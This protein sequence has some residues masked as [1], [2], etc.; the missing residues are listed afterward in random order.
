[1]TYQEIITQLQV[2]QK[3]LAEERDKLQELAGEIAELEE[4]SE[5]ALDA[6]YDAIEA[7]S[8]LI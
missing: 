3:G 8:E 5:R 2:R 4:V 7:L 6:L 1:M